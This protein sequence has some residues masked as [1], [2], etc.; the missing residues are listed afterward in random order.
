MDTNTRACA[1]ILFISSQTE[2]SPQMPFQ[3]RA[4]QDTYTLTQ[5][6]CFRSIPVCHCNESHCDHC[7]SCGHH[8]LT[9][10]HAHVHIRM[11]IYMPMQRSRWLSSHSSCDPSWSI[12]WESG[13]P[14][15]MGS[16]GG[17]V[18]SEWSQHRV[19]VKGELGEK[20]RNEKLHLWIHY[21][22]QMQSPVKPQ[23]G[24][25]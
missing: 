9:N 3:Q 24:S 12:L 2:H 15:E 18:K 23:T 14:L 10:T 8:S 17:G 16:G 6:Q 20:V 19:M 22:E 1:H 5:S 11:H 7:V 13:D 21:E 4:C 25:T